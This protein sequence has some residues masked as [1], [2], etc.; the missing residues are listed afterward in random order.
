MYYGRMRRRRAIKRSR[1]TLD[2][3]ANKE[4]DK[5]DD[6]SFKGYVSVEVTGAIKHDRKRKIIVSSF[7]GDD[8]AR[9]EGERK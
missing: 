1:K 4:I 5:C 8:E 9:H 6:V 2:T 7:E 3:G